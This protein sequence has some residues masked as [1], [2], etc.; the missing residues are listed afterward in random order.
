M[1]DRDEYISSLYAQLNIWNYDIDTMCAKA[2]KV[3]GDKIN[4]YNKQIELLLSIQSVA[5][6]K[7]QKL[8]DAQENIW[9]QMKPEIELTWT[10][11][12]KTLDTARHHFR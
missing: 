9:E 12:G 1:N 4:E 11:M 2:D 7:I 10:E 5:R 8:Q 6:Q 3:T